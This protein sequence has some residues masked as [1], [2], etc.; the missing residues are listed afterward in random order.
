M[1]RA[2]RCMVLWRFWS[3]AAASAQIWHLAGAEMAQQASSFCRG[4]GGAGGNFRAFPEPRQRAPPCLLVF[5]PRNSSSSFYT[6]TP[7]NPVVFERAGVVT[8]AATSTNRMA[9]WIVVVDTPYYAQA[10]EGAAQVQINGVPAGNYK[11]A[12]LAPRMAPGAAA[13]SNRWHCLP[14]AMMRCGQA[15]GVGA[16]MWRI[17]GRSLILRLV[18]CPCCCC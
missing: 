7:A 4:T 14:P 2:A 15:G 12:R 11:A 10:A 8:L 17:L 13:M 5:L 1:R 3:L 6:G 18:G 16:L 9:G